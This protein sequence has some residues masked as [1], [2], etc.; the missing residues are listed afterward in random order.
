MKI[1]T[2][3]RSCIKDG[4]LAYCITEAVFTDKESARAFAKKQVLEQADLWKV[5]PQTFRKV[6]GY[7][8]AIELKHPTRNV[9]ITVILEAK[10]LN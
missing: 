6:K 2:V 1:F 5:E 9:V 8:N 3:T 10:E 7:Y 4:K